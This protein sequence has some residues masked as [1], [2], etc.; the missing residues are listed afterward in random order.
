MWRLKGHHI[1]TTEGTVLIAITSVFTDLL[2][3]AM[4]NLKAAW[5]ASE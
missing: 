1:A 5:F 3:H 2:I 4:R